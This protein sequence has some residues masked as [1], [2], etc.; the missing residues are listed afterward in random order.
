MGAS[1][2]GRRFEEAKADR[3]FWGGLGAPIET[4]LP[5]D[6]S[7]DWFKLWNGDDSPAVS[8]HSSRHLEDFRKSDACVLLGAP[9]AGKTVAF[10]QEAE[11]DGCHYVTAC[12]FITF[13]DRLEWRSVTLFNVG[14]YARSLRKTR[15]FPAE[16][17]CGSSSLPVGTSHTR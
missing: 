17:G 16:T 12:D 1:P 9:G 14:S 15:E 2:E 4:V 3:S 11:C 7:I 5:S 10:G 6:E 8:D 13:D